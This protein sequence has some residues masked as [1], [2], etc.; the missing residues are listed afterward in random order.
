MRTVLYAGI[1]CNRQDRPGRGGRTAGCFARVN[2]T[3]RVLA[4][5]TSAKR[6]VQ[7]LS[8][9]PEGF[10][11]PWQR[12]SSLCRSLNFDAPPLDFQLAVLPGPKARSAPGAVVARLTPRNEERKCARRSRRPRSLSTEIDTYHDS[13]SPEY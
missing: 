9:T 2:P 13:P 6:L 7:G 11:G 10:G 3:D 4:G 12:R 5:K 8:F 1:S